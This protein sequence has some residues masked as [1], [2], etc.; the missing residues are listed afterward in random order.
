MMDAYQ[1]GMIELC[2][3][4]EKGAFMCPDN[5]VLRADAANILALAID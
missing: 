5:V 1:R 4:G 2:Y 3:D